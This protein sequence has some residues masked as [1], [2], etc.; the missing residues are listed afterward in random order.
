MYYMGAAGSIEAI[1]C[2][3]DLYDNFISMTVGYKSFEPECD[4]NYVTE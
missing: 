3:M 1:V 4:L 2:N